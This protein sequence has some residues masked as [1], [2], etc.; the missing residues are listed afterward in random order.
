MVVRL[1]AVIGILRISGDIVSM[2]SKYNPIIYTSVSLT[3]SD[4]W[5]INQKRAENEAL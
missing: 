5:N 2:P 3:G 1:S 4:S